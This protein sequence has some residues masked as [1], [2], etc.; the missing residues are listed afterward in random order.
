MRL[1]LALIILFAIGISQAEYPVVKI[2]DSESSIKISNTSLPTLTVGGT[3]SLQISLM[4]SDVHETNL[5]ARLDV[6]SGWLSRPESVK[7]IIKPESS[8][9]LVFTVSVPGD[10]QH[11][12]SIIS[13][14]VSYDGG[15]SVF[16]IPVIVEGQKSQDTLLTLPVIILCAVGFV[17]FFTR[18]QNHRMMEK[19]KMLNTLKK[20]R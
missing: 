4:N 10:A 6:Q 7:K 20:V 14:R 1:S 3:H 18:W 5:T 8:E 15:E 19:I 13:L 11:G 16:S 9:T 2:V 17:A 12:T